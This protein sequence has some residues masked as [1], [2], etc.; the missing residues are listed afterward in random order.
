MKVKKDRLSEC[1]SGMRE[2]GKQLAI[3]IDMYMIEEV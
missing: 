1:I 2:K 3:E